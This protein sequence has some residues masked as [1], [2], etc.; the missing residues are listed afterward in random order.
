MLQKQ[1]V[2]YGIFIVQ[3][4]ISLPQ[5]SEPFTRNSKNTA[6]IKSIPALIL[7]MILSF[8]NQAQNDQHAYRI[9]CVGFYNLENLFDTID[10][11]KKNDDA[12]TPGGANAWTG[13]RFREKIANLARVIS[14]LG[15]DITPDGAAILGLSEVEN[16]HVVREL[17]QTPELID[18]NYKVIHRESPD[19]RGIDNALIY[20]PKYF[21]PLN[22]KTYTLTIPGLDNFKT[23]DQ[24]LV[25]GIL[26]QDTVH[27]LVN[28]WPSRRGG[29]ARSMPRRIA[30]AQLSRHIVDSLQQMQSGAK[31]IIMGD[32]NDDPKDPS[33]KKHLN[34]KGERQDLNPGDLYN[35]YERMH[36]T[37]IGTLAYRDVWNLFDMIILSESLSG[38]EMD[39]YTLFK[40]FVYKKD[41][42]IQKN[43]RYKGYPLRTFGGGVYLSGYSDHFPVYV[44]LI[45]KV[46]D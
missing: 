11:P 31:I 29:E 24:L 4:T 39:N 44:L 13:S 43:G 36:E 23:R 3:I 45:K 22:I 37:G 25:S 15:T 20:Q 30:A 12:F 32:L 16:D 17:I 33:I 28:H 26:D 19:Y 5:E 2:V 38:E 7:L 34:V 18:R 42:L 14:E 35:P 1:D 9:V 41:Y 40:P 8:S 27:I 46:G 21:Q 6:M 10:D